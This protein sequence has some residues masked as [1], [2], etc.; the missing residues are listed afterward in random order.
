M[1]SESPAICAPLWLGITLLSAACAAPP[2]GGPESSGAGPGDRALALRGE[3]TRELLLTGE[4]EAVHSISIKAP[5]TAVFQMRIQYLAE[6]GSVVEKGD[7]LLD[8]DNSAVADRVLDL[9]TQI[10][11][12]ETQVVVRRNEIETILRDLDIEL[13]SKQ[14]EHDV[15]RVEAAVERGILSRKEYG[16]RQLAFESAVRELEEIRKRIDS[17]RKEGEADL[18]VL[19]IERDKL[20]QDLAAARHDLEVLSIK[21]PSDGLVIY[22]TRPRST[23]RY[24]EGDS[25]WPGQSVLRL[26]DLSAMQVLFHVNEVDARLLKIG[27][28]VRV[29]LD[30]FPGRELDGE[31]VRI[32][33]MAV[34]RDE[35]SSVRIFK[36]VARLAETWEEEMKP[37]MS[38]LGRLVVERR[39]GAPMV[40]RRAVRFD[41]ESYWLRLPSAD[42]PSGAPLRIHPVAR[43]ASHYVLDEEKDAQVLGLLGLAGEGHPGAGPGASS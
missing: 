13:A 6:E 42:G 20:G 25:C 14:Y 17:T 36:V 29:S 21:A 8:F 33:S 39:A 22:E 38:V 3:F 7:P 11:D 19:I 16:E 15:A 37:G 4:L 18:D 10:L 28:P 41:G 35:S 34:S 24:Q 1:S 43:N 5:Q 27:M 23:T 9:E 40:A 32:P 26:P 12:A 30:A 2:A 31:I